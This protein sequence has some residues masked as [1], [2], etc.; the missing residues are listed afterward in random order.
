M[1]TG[2]V[3]QFPEVKSKI[4]W[5]PALG[6]IRFGAGPEGGTFIYK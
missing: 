2:K 4:P 1:F 3:P 5:S 6:R